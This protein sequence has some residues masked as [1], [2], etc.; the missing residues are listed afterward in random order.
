VIE[1]LCVCARELWPYSKKASS[2]FE[3][4]QSGE[5]NPGQLKGRQS[6]CNA[7][8]VGGS[9]RIVVVLFRRSVSVVR[10]CGK[11][12]VCGSRVRR[13]GAVNALV[14]KESPPSAEWKSP[15]SIRKEVES[16]FT[17]SGQPAKP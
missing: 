14:K 2:N 12:P 6:G 1:T 11:L 5:T 9:S 7:A 8:A 16:S 13:C 17:S 15:S 4:G 3:R 10:A